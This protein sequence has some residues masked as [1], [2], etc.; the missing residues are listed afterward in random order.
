[1]TAL[2]TQL[3]KNNIYLYIFFQSCF[4]FWWSKLKA[5]LD[6]NRD[7]PTLHQYWQEQLW[8][9]L[10][11]LPFPHWRHH[12]HKAS[13]MWL[14][15]TAEENGTD[16][17]MLGCICLPDWHTTSRPE[18][19]LFCLKLK[20]PAAMPHLVCS[21]AACSFAA[22]SFAVCLQNHRR[23]SILASWSVSEPPVLVWIQTHY[24]I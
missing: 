9:T 24:Y 7:T 23:S 15:V 4:R 8:N 10:S 11:L 14:L 5:H 3:K 17:G 18:V 2:Q 6:R 12:G 22:C 19:S 21:I 20:A 16:R 1:M 13:N